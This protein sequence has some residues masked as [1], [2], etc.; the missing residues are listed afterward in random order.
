MHKDRDVWGIQLGWGEK[1]TSYTTYW[2]CLCWFFFFFFTTFLD[3][4]S[5]WLNERHKMKTQETKCQP[6]LTLVPN[7]HRVSGTQ[8]PYSWPMTAEKRR[9]S[10][11]LLRLWLA[12][13]LSFLSPEDD[14]S[15]GS[16]IF[17]WEN[18]EIRDRDGTFTFGK[19]LGESKACHRSPTLP[20]NYY[21]NVFLFS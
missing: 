12:V 13:F 18:S 21:F 1:K 6:S 16:F 17:Q 5:W 20:G 3:I 10:G 15:N 2:S 11:N 4:F 14:P 8:F 9:D 19:F 7:H